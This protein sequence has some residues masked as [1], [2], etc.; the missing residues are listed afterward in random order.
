MVLALL[1]PVIVTASSQAAGAELTTVIA[2]DADAVVDS[3]RP[4]KNYGASRLL[5]I[6]GSPVVRTYLRFSVGA[7]SGEVVKAELLVST[8][9][10]TTSSTSVALSS[11]AWAERT[12][13][14]QNA[15]QPG[16]S[17]ATAAPVKAGGTLTA[18]VTSAVQQPGTV[19]FVLTTPSSTNVAMHSRESSAAAP[20][21]LRLTVKQAPTSTPTPTATTS[22][23]ASPTPTGSATP[24]PTPTGQGPI[25]AT[26]YYPWFPEA[27]KQQ[28]FDPFTRYVP[29]AG[30]YD[31]SAPALI[32]QHIDSMVYAGMDAGIASWWG[33]GSRTDTRIGALLSR[34]AGK[35]FTW[36]L[37]YER[38]GSSDPSASTIAADL[39]YVKANYATNP[40]YL[41]VGGKPV[42]FVYADPGDGCGM[43]DRWAAGNASAGFHVVLKNF[44]GY[45]TCASQPGDWHQ[46]APANA[47]QVST[48][49]YS[50]SPGFWRPDESAR[51]V[52]DPARFA[53][54]VAAMVASGKRWQLV[55]T[56]NEWGEGTSVESA[57][58]WATSSGHGTYADILHRALVGT[59]STPTP[60]PTPTTS[61][62]PTASATPTPTPTPSTTPTGGALVA[63]VGD[64]A[65]S[66]TSSSFKG[67]LGTST[68]CRQQ[69]V[70]DLLAGRDVSAFL[71]LGDIQYECGDLAEFRASYDLAWGRY[72][73]ITRPVVGNHE[74]GT[75][76]GR[77]EASGYFTYFGDRAGPA[78]KGWYSYDI[79]DWHLI[80]L[81]SQCHYGTTGVLVGGCSTSSAQYAWL[82]Q[83]LA[84]HPNRCTIAYWHE[85]RWSSGKHGNA[86]S[87]SDIWNLLVTSG[88]ELALAGHNHSYERF[89]PLG[90]APK[91][92]SSSVQQPTP[93]PN[94]MRQFVVGTGGKT[95]YDF[96]APMLTGETVRNGDTFGVL[97]LTLG[98]GTY[99]W[100]FVPEAGKT[101]TD[102]G[103]ATCR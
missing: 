71:P 40:A 8:K 11:A 1:A 54:N 10:A 86:Q 63:A 69:A 76:C 53:S 45:A 92:T 26:F 29:S 9:S 57:T 43:A 47:T 61:A 74:Y 95:H 25:R 97:F 2:T 73:D 56:W 59:G 22:A 6:D 42:I 75:S 33:Q 85:P 49:S 103:S 81:N 77:N 67:G 32:D 39:A 87:M 18:D 31:S 5:R 102:S 28:G 101:F 23:M 52:R 72:M 70:A 14:Y 89:E 68:S 35:P 93:D 62:T 27:W 90:T 83:D 37:Y 66:S 13:T 7:L 94:G 44:S 96:T 60:T 19:G 3:A 80:A 88:A 46:Y 20:A 21:Q 50:V 16:A 48:T 58:Q 98:D 65:C 91:D 55:T 64:I 100:E 4:T 17:F 24:T 30:W 78:G 34:A 15:P 79:G 36:A 51:L 41:K 99:S 38:E 84:A 82:Q 12:L